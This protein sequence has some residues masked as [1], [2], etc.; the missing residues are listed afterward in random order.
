[1]LALLALGALAPATGG[2]CVAGF[3]PPSLVNTLR[4]FAVTADSPYALPGQEVTFKMTYHD[5]YP[6]PEEG[7]R[8]VQIVWIGGCFDPPGDQYF[9]CYEQL[10]DLFKGIQAGAP[11]PSGYFAAGIGLDEFKITMP[12]DIVSRR[13]PP[14]TGP[15]YG[16][17]YVFFAACAGQIGPVLDE[18]GKAG[19]FPLGCFDADGRRLGSESFVPGYTQIYVFDD[20][21]DNPNPELKGITLD[22]K[23]LPEDFAEIPTV[24]R[25]DV[26]E[27][28]RRE[29]GCGK[30]DPT[31]EC[32]TYEIEAMVDPG[33]ADIDE[34]STGKDGGHLTEVVWVDYF[35]DQGDL[36]SGVKLVNDAVEGYNDEHEVKWIPPDAPGVA[37]IWAVLHD[38][39]G[40]SSV[41]QRFVRVE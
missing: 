1:M 36:V 12:E 35:A 32:T 7:P 13:P 28:E 14:Q 25:C 10:A 31:S 20:G 22:G 29:A 27:E 23:E 26:S 38:A 19:S 33:V 6:G 41:T 21:R 3:D 17:A 11:P 16:I 4:I 24:K 2:G 40:G 5:G 34:E 18:G 39:R 9:A 8:P 30:Q 15:Y 37:T